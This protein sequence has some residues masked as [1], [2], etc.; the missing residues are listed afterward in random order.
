MALSKSWGM[1][2]AV[3]LFS[4]ALGTV[5]VFS[6]YEI[7]NEQ[8]NFAGQLIFTLTGST[9]AAG[10]FVGGMKHRNSVAGLAQTSKEIIEQARKDLEDLKPS[11]DEK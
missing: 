2:I 4:A 8:I 11:G 1:I 7:S 3:Y 6:G 10:A 5:I 9:S